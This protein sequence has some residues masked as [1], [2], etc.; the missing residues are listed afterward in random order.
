MTGPFAVQEY[1]QELIRH[2]PGDI[3]KIIEPP[4]DVDVS[5][6]QYEH[7]RQFISELNL[8]VVYLEDA[9]TLTTCPKMKAT[10]E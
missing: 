8:L 1:I 4:Q 9:C 5:V 3:K 10:D 2:N 6:W 7:M